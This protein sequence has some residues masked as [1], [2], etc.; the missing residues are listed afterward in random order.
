MTE[1]GELHEKQIQAISA[2]SVVVKEIAR[3]LTGYLGIDL[4]AEID[5]LDKKLSLL[6]DEITEGKENADT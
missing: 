2:I 1:T 3:E 6:N 5:D 4:R